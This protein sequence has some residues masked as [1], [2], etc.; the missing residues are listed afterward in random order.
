MNTP[1]SK[2]KNALNPKNWIRDYR[3]YLVRYAQQ[4][5]SDHGIAEDLVQ[6]TFLSAWNARERFRGD[7]AERTWLTGVL[8]NKIVDH[9]RRKARRPMTLAG[10]VEF[11]SEDGGPA[12]PWLENRA[13]ERDTFDP[14]AATVRAEFMTML[15]QAVDRLP[16]SMGRA[17]RMREM[18][19]YSTDEITRSLNISKGNL[20]VLIHRAKQMLKEQLGAVWFGNDMGTGAAA[21]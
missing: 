8:R 3:D 1:Q 10:D 12:T 18:Q 17:F 7:C 6:E 14:D 2:P 19:G 21:A 11:D 20:W 5:V 4:R 16:D 9:Y 13:N 15:D